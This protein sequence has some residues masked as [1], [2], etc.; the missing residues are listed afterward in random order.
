MILSPLPLREAERGLDPSAPL[1]GALEDRRRLPVSIFHFRAAKTP[2][3]YQTLP[4]NK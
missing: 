1:S 3:F 4:A 2:T